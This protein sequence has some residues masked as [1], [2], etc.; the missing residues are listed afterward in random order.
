MR[1]RPPAS[2]PVVHCASLCLYCTAR[3]VVESALSSDAARAPLLQSRSLQLAHLLCP[4]LPL[5]TQ[6]ALAS[7]A[8]TG[9]MTPEVAAGVVER[10]D[11][12]LALRD[13]VAVGAVRVFALM[14]AG[15]ADAAFP[16]IDARVKRRRRGVFKA[17]L[18][19]LRQI[20]AAQF[21]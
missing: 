16:R 13:V 8:W 7:D 21:G 15:V 12:L 2:A 6:P 17:E 10:V 5:S 3:Q 18:Y 9:A 14:R 1:V 4:P 20:I 11:L 19:A